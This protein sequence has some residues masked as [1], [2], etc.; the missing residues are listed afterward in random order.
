MEKLSKRPPAVPR[1]GKPKTRK[2]EDGELQLTNRFLKGNAAYLRGIAALQ[3][4]DAKGA[5]P[6]L[7]A[8]TSQVPE[9]SV[10]WQKLAVALAGIGDAEHAAQA[11][12]KAVEMNPC[13]R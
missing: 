1:W 13:L 12:M 4:G 8:A 3:A 9:D 5:V 11:R 2:K 6:H 10:A 7:E